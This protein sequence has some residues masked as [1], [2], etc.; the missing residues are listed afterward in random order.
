MFKYFTMAIVI[1]LLGVA[2]S[3]AAPVFNYTFQDR[4]VL[5][6]NILTNQTQESRAPD[7]GR[8][9]STVGVTGA[10]GAQQDSTLGANAI[11][12]QGAASGADS[13][14]A[15]I[16]SSIDVKFT[17]SADMNFD[18]SFTLGAGDPFG[19][20]FVQL[21]FMDGPMPIS[22]GSSAGPITGH[23]FLFEGPYELQLGA[24]PAPSGG[25]ATYLF[26]M[27]PTAIPVV[28]LPP[29]IWAGLATLGG[30]AGLKCRRAWTRQ[31]A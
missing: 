2:R 8:F 14:A 17:L 10:G 27:A 25:S 31:M 21:I 11:D 7:F 22:Q 15:T 6:T 13:Q 24:T 4:S 16:D 26:H 30:L 18:Y 1:S 5:A 23:V 9:V 29:A 28:P 20:S 19:H 12:A 3:N